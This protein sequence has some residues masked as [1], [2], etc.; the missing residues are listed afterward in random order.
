[1]VLVVAVV[2]DLNCGVELVPRM[3]GVGVVEEEVVVVAAA[4]L[5]AGVAVW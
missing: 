4:V 1:V 3:L 2:V 5:A